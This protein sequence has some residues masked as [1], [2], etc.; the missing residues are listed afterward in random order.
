MRPRSH[1]KARYRSDLPVHV[2]IPDTQVR[3]GYPVDHLRHVGQ[4]IADRFAGHPDVTIIHVGD[5]WDMPSLS[6]YDKGKGVMEGRRYAD[7]VKAGNAA[8]RALNAPLAARKTWNPRK[9]FLFGNHENRIVR[10][11]NDNI[12]LEGTISLDD[13]DTL[14]WER[15]EFLRPVIIGGVHYAHYWVNP[16]SGRPWTGTIDSMLKNIGHSFTQGHRQVL[17]YGVRPVSTNFHH[18]LVAGACYAHDED[19][20][21]PQGNNNW[22]GI[23]VKHQVQDGS[24]DPAFV[25]LDYLFRRYS[26]ISLAEYKR[27]CYTG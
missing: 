27:N 24:Y 2:V 16:L 7:D 19:Y 9:V 8:F 22:R 18:G 4:Y 13:L 23:I 12:Q 15:H 10:A 11:L 25:S 14:D 26:G 21:T 1:K 17:L 3:P 6:S 20:L 5:H